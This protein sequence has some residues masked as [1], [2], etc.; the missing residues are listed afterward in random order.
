MVEDTNPEAVILPVRD[1]MNA[2]EAISWI[3]HGKALQKYDWCRDLFRL[4]R[5]WEFKDGIGIDTNDPP[6]D[7]LY[8][9]GWNSSAD[10]LLP[11][12]K[13]RASGSIWPSYPRITSEKGRKLA[14]EYL[15]RFDVRDVASWT[16]LGQELKGIF[17]DAIHS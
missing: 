12:F 7:R 2:A 11:T 8:M 5:D 9:D 17:S 3:G 1:F 14:E 15:A 4:S 10:E 16:L 13:A 6:P